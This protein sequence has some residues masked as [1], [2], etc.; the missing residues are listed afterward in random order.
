MPY[1]QVS[2]KHGKH[3]CY[4]VVNKQTGHKFSSCTT[5]E[6]AHAQMNLLRGVEHGWHP[7]HNVGHHARKH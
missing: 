7:T 4:G 1:G 3:R 5:K 6:K 2:K